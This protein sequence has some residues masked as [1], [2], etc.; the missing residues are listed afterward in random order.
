M[1]HHPHHA[2]EKRILKALLL[3]GIFMLVEVAGGLYAGSLALLADAGHMLTDTAALALAYGA[4]RLSRRPA[5]QMRTY[6]YDRF[7]VLAAF[8]N[9]LVL[10]GIFIW[11]VKEAIERIMAP[12]DVLA[13]PMLV[14]AT[15]G[16][17]INLISFKILHPGS[18]E[19]LNIKGALLHVAFDILGSIG[20]IIA[21]VVIYFTGWMKI[22]PILSIFL[23]AMIL[24]SA[25][26]LVKKATH[27]LME[28][29]PDSFD[30][31]ALK[32]DLVSHIPGLKDIHHVHV[33]L[34]TAERPLLS[35]HATVG[36][37]KKSEKIL[38]GIKKRLVDEHGINH[39]TVQIETEGCADH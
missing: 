7:Q 12:S 21:A 19:N 9:G 18:K 11:I 14:V 8:I 38:L 16:L 1:A 39:S 10:F 15:A 35:M 26:N 25:W 27:I 32:K 20:A 31:E 34:L 28:G 24:P 29:T 36:D 22:D 6:G 2:N 3:T 30:V 5:D 13:I 23:A 33:W 17:I 37:I 4:F